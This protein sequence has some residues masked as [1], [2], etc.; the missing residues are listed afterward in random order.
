[1]SRLD[2]FLK[3][4]KPSDYVEKVAVSPDFTEE[5]GSVVLWELK[6][7]SA[8]VDEMLR[9]SCLKRVKGSFELD[10]N[11]YGA[12]LAAATVVFPDLNDVNLQDSYGVMGADRLLREMLKAGEYQRLLKKVKEINGFGEVTEDL[13]DEAKN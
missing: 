4:R 5:D 12:K 9:L 6:P 7:V 13:I 10:T 3:S 8:S 2:L 11:M 1:M